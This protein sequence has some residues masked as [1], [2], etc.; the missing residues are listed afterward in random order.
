[1]WA[2]IRSEVRVDMWK[3]LGAWES[4]HHRMM[5]WRLGPGVI[6]TSSLILQMAKLREESCRHGTFSK[7]INETSGTDLTQPTPVFQLH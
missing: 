2:E 3:H 6:D 5:S 1:M 7:V 4:G